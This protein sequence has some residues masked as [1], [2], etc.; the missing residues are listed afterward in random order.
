MSRTDASGARRRLL[1]QQR[2]RLDQAL[3]VAARLPGYRNVLARLPTRLDPAERLVR[4]PVLERRQLQ[5]DPEFFRDRSRSS[6]G[7]HTSGS[8]A[9]PLTY[10]LDR[11][12]RLRRLA[13]Y[14]RFFSLH[15]WRPWHCSLSFKVLP[16]SSD[17]VGSRWLDHSLLVRRRVVSVLDPPEAQ[18][19]IFRATDPHILHGLPSILQQLV[20]QMRRQS[21]RPSR[22]QRIFTSSEA[23]ESRTRDRLEGILGAPVVDHYGAAEG[24]IGWECERRN[25]YHLN[26][27]SI[28][29]EILD[30]EGES[31]APGAVGRIVITTLDNPAMPLV[32]YAIGDHAV[33][34]DEGMCPCGRAEPLI[35]KV[36]G[37][38]WICSTFPPVRCRHGPRSRACEKSESPD[39]K[40]GRSYTFRKSKWR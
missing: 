5:A 4:L 3:T 10:Y 25:G 17:R 28:F 23:L 14:A 33:R 12:A 37:G 21:W 26:M 36:I 7:I 11:R 31:V 34:G 16:D 19:R 13:E 29:L 15:G 22:L 27:R 30:T 24:F 1:V 20:I 32:R 38:P 8:T 35:P 40:V 18:F 39:I 2:G 9:T 6:I